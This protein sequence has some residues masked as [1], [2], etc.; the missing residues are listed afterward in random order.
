MHIEQIGDGSAL[1]E[2][3]SPVESSLCDNTATECAAVPAGPTESA[4]TRQTANGEQ[5]WTTQAFT[6]GITFV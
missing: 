6:I 2:T 1:A 4:A 3:S 5:D